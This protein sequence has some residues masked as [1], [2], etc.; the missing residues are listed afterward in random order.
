MGV[1]IENA[2]YRF[3]ANHLRQTPAKTK[4]LSIEPL[5]GPVG[6]LDLDGIDWVIVGG[7]SGHSLGRSS[8]SGWSTSGINAS[9]RTYCSSSSNGV[10]E[11]PR[12]AAESSMDDIGM[13]CPV[14]W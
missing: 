6:E 4:F 8:A 3:R 12:L 10:A 2:R 7:E 9:T 5:I 1:S 13:T 11:H 14:P